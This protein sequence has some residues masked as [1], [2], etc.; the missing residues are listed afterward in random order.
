MKNRQEATV[1]EWG[2]L[3]QQAERLGEMRPWETFKVDE[4]MALNF[5]K[6]SQ[7]VY[8]NILGNPVGIEG[9]CFYE[10]QI[11]FDN[12][13]DICQNDL[14]YYPSDYA[15]YTQNCL[16]VQWG[17]RDDLRNA[18]RAIIRELGIK[19]R[20]PKQWLY[21]LSY[22]NG[23][24]PFNPDKREVKSLTRYITKLIKALEYYKDH[25]IQGDFAAR[26]IYDFRQNTKTE[27]WQGKAMPRPKRTAF[28]YL[29]LG[30]PKEVEEMRALKKTYTTLEIDV[31]HY[32][33]PVKDDS[34]DRPINP[35]MIFFAD[36]ETKEIVHFSTCGPDEVAGEEIFDLLMNY[37]DQ[38][39]RPQKILIRNLVLK[40]YLKHLCES[41]G[42]ELILETELTAIDL[43]LI[44]YLDS[45]YFKGLVTRPH[46][47]TYKSIHGNQTSKQK[48]K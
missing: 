11:G 26:E 7:P 31:I 5:P 1:E 12:F 10:G 4:L 40:R 48:G 22:K 44:K 46:T 25:P 42:I 17:D 23:Y 20:G 45:A 47:K 37:C 36:H 38:V 6:T 14:R 34:F 39:G 15:A 24:F 33:A 13:W 21:F 35:L 28:K 43:Y 32:G 30:N 2:R 27:E 3:Y 41:C 8:C 16:T 9:A 29:T 18:Q 19:Y